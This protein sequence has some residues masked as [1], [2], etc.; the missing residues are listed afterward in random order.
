MSY[1]THTYLN[2]HL[3]SLLKFLSELGSAQCMEAER[4]YSEAG[5][6]RAGSNGF[7]TLG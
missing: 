5:K 3:Q 7:A 4:E 6:L 2:K 1:M